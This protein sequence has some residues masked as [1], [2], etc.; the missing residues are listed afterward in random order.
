MH[1]SLQDAILPNPMSAAAMALP[2]LSI[3]GDWGVFSTAVTRY[4]PS[5]LKSF[6]QMGPQGD[7]SATSF[8]DPS[9][10]SSTRAKSNGAL[11]AEMFIRAKKAVVSNALM[12]NTLDL[13]PKEV[14]PKSYQD[15]I[16]MTPQ[17]ESFMHL[18]HRS[19]EDI[20]YPCQMSLYVVPGP[21]TL[22]PGF[23]RDKCEVKL[24]GP[25][26]THKKFLQRNRGTY[27]PTIEAVAASGALVANSLVSVSQHSQLL[28][29][30]GM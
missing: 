23:D 6:A 7:L 22:G 5:L 18:T 2:P 29:A 4:A 1:Q 21:W 14:I 16:K 25:Q 9:Q 24:F 26:L 8:S 19:M 15:R 10:K 27:G 12:W 3:R 13:L 17:C 11:S 30:V 28:D 20:R